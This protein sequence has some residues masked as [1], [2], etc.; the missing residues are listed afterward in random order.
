MGINHAAAFLRADGNGSGEVATPLTEIVRHARYVADRIGVDHVALGSDYDGARIPSDM[1]DVTGLPRLIEAFR[2]AGFDE[3][4]IEQV[5][6]R[7]WLRVLGET[8]RD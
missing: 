4:E 3:K 2:D 5:A 6:Y 8:W 7:N 1:G